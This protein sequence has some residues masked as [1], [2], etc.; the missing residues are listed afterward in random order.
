MEHF[1]SLKDFTKEEI[2]EIIEVG[3]KIKKET[4]NKIFQPY[5]RNMNLGMI[6]KKVLQE[7]EFHLKLESINL[8]DTDYFYQIK[9]FNLEEGNR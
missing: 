5:L 6:L 4:K 9:R 2:L 7:Q 1:L 3:L 8:G